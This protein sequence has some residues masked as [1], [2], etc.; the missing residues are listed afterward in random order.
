MRH[1]ACMVI[2]GLLTF[3][4][5]AANSSAVEL[6][7]EPN[8]TKTDVLRYTYSWPYSGDSEMTPRGGITRGPEVYLS[9]EPSTQFLR[10]QTDDLSDKARDRL[11]II[12]LAGDYRTSF[13]FI[14]TMGFVP[15]YKPPKPYQ[16]WG[17]E[18]VY[19]IQDSENF[20]SLQHILVMRFE[21]D[22]GEISE[23]MVVKHWRQDWRYEDTVTH[24]YQGHGVYER[25]DHRAQDIR[26]YWTQTVYQVDD[27]PRY[28][29]M[30][31]WHHRPGLSEWQSTEKRRPLPR[32]EFS[33]R[34]DYQ[35]L[36]GRH[37]ITI[38][39]S[40][41]IQEED[42]LKLVLKP[43]NETPE[44]GAMLAREAG[45]SRYERITG[46]DF[47]AGDAYW[48]KSESFWRDV[49]AYW[50][51][52]YESSQSFE[53][54]KRVGEEVLFATL[55]DMANSTYKDSKTRQEII[56]QTIQR[57]VQRKKVMSKGN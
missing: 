2:F 34:N 55:F 7:D 26:G 25:R 53:V 48:E 15:N 39:Q 50:S 36:L 18:R 29:A 57:F 24:D 47:D 9:E 14:E 31:K 37:R 22:D 40:G 10:L 28:E 11:A 46:Y 23:P 51:E 19:L 52:V 4:S 49:R 38:T 27:S 41:W 5:M 3:V 42:S 45:I 54:K 21:S 43:N 20:I 17:T 33:V 13:D 1:K 16:S 35:T 30:G 44:T 56:Q 12:S 6:S 8:S 32:R